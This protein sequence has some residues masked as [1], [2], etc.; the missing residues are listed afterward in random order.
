[1]KKEEERRRKNNKNNQSLTK[2]K[3]KRK[4]KKKK[5]PQIAISNDI[6]LTSNS[7]LFPFRPLFSSLCPLFHYHEEEEEEEAKE[8]I[9]GSSMPKRRLWKD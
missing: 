5:T 9:E 3:E 7:P 8:D 1:M 6:S 4:E 2:H